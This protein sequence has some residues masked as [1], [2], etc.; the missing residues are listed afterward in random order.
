LFFKISCLVWSVEHNSAKENIT[1]KLESICVHSAMP[2]LIF[3]SLI[4][5][6]VPP[7]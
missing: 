7:K 2:T 6:L 3:T 5:R 4:L 1:I